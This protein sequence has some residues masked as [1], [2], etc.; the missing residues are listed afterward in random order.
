MLGEMQELQQLQ[1]E[2]QKQE[3]LHVSVTGK[4]MSGVPP[5]SLNHSLRVI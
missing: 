5:P 3:E 2:Q 4:Q 1:T